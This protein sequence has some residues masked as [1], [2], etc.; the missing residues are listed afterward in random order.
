M[1]VLQSTFD[2][3]NAVSYPGSPGNGELSNDISLNLEGSTAC[4]FGR[5]VYRGAADKGAVLT[6]SANNLRGF[7]LRNQ[8]MPETST[9]AVDTYAPGDTMAVRERGTIYVTAA[10]AVT[11]GAAVFVTAAGALTDA[12]SGNTAATGWVFDQ[13]TTAAGLVRIARR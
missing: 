10:K 13:T 9:R 6:V 3:T 1:A 2:E 11:D 5:P 7:A 8:V 12:S 4:E